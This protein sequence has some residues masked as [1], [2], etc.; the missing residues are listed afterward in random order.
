MLLQNISICHF[1]GGREEEEGERR[2]GEGV[3][4]EGGERGMPFL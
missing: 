2:G 4:K 1:K 3:K